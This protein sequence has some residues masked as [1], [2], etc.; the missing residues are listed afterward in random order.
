MSD[1]TNVTTA[2]V[3][4]N[5]NA[6]TAALVSK[7]DSKTAR[8][9]A[10][11]VALE[12][13]TFTDTGAY[14]DVA[15]KQPL[16]IYVHTSGSLY[17]CSLDNSND[18]DSSVN[19]SLQ[20]KRLQAVKYALRNSVYRA[21]TRDLTEARI[22]VTTV[23]EKNAKLE[24]ENALANAKNAV[25]MFAMSMPNAALTA[26]QYATVQLGEST[27]FAELAKANAAAGKRLEAFAKKEAAGIAAAVEASKK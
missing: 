13:V 5:A 11:K 15:F 18:I 10:F 22:T 2:V 27:F 21:A 7:K 19:E 8:K 20:E 24:T 1:S 4:T 3:E 12:T 16:R 25:L 17:F 14:V 23:R 26:V 9:D 6:K